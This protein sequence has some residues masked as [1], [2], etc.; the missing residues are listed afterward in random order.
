MKKIAILASALAL[1]TFASCN[2][3]P[4]V[5][6]DEVIEDGFFVAGPATG[7]EELQAKYAMVAGFNENGKKTRD[8]MYEK[9]IVLEKDKDFYLLL[10]EAGESVRYSATLET[11]NPGLSTGEGFAENPNYDTYRGQLE[12]GNEGL[13]MRVP[14][15]GLYHI[16]LDLNIDA[17][18]PLDY[19]Q[20]LVAPCEFSISNGDKAMELAVNGDKYTWTYTGSNATAGQ[21][22]K[23]R[24]CLG[25]KITLDEGGLVKA[26][27]SF[28]LADNGISITPLGGADIPYPTGENFT[29]SLTFQAKP[30]AHSESF[31][32]NIE[33]AT[34][35]EPKDWTLG[36]KGVLY[37]GVM[38]EWDGA[39]A[40]ARTK[41]VYN[42]TK[43]KPAENTYVY[44][45]KGCEIKKDA[46]FK[47]GI[48]GIDIKGTASYLKFEGVQVTSD[49]DANCIFGSEGAK[50]DIELTIVPQGQGY[51]SIVAKFTK[52]GE[53][54]EAPELPV[55]PEA[56]W[57][58]G[59]AATSDAAAAWDWAK[60]PAFNKVIEKPG[61]F[62]ML[63]YLTAGTTGFKF[64]TQ[65]NWNGTQ[66]TGLTTNTGYT[67]G[68]DNGNSSVSEAGLYLIYVNYEASSVTIE[69]AK[70]YGIGAA[71][72]KGE[73][74]PGD[75]TAKFTVNA[76]GTASAVATKPGD[77][78]VYVDFNNNQLSAWW[79]REFKP[80]NGVI[81]Y[82]VDP[83]LAASNIEAGKKLTLDFNAGTG[84]IE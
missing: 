57:I 28:G 31:S 54:S 1:L 9:Y 66:Y 81:T 47:F 13:A 3:G 60:A 7:S 2:K 40:D 69:P 14:K 58:I 38:P 35:V 65:Q 16:V 5:N 63:R 45:I 26:E 29:I 50:Y 62:Y 52:V 71:F 79:T 51:K 74:N 78:R 20:I 21:N 25:W 23:F 73:W 30:G 4:G 24:H 37:A 18:A 12:I 53:L 46:M 19:E 43:S 44:D 34:V 33:G 15:T 75:E 64:N 17:E 61:H 67:V 70:I 82:R 83:E 10:N 76:D 49:K 48:Q 22:F 11:F 27:T 68:T 6:L 8:G 42:E 84:V 80:I 59:D 55:Y 72:G 32:Y 41:G 39:F 56:L 36:I 77:I